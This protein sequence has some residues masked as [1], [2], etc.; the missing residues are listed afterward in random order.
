MSQ[1]ASPGLDSVVIFRL[2][3]QAFAIPVDDVREVVPIAWLAKPPQLPSFVEGILN[4]AGAAIPVLRLDMLMGV[5]DSRFG[6]EASILIMRGD[7]PVGLLVEHVDGVKRT[8]TFTHIPV[9]PASSF[10]GC[11]AGE[12][13]GEGGSVIHLVSWENLLLA[14][15]RQR[16]DDFR[17][18]ADQRLAELAEPA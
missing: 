4:L 12:L 7:N 6:L 14:E 3:G 11:L 8:G 15:E 18:R 9:D 2:G 16:L 1:H 13:A 17:S 5:A 10:N